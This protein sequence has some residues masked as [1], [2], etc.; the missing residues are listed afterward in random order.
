M[1]DVRDDGSFRLN[2]K[3]FTYHTGLTMTGRKFAKLFGVPRRKPETDTPPGRTWT[4]AASI[5]VVLEEIMEKIVRCATEEIAS[6]N[7]CLAGGVALNCVANGKI[8]K[9]QI[10]KNVWI[11][12]AAGDAGGAAGRGAVRLV[13]APEESRGQPTGESDSQ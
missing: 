8:L 7:L 5:Q 2:L 4:S 6:D 11:Q 1:I 3:Y 9:K 12:P 13:Q 10:F